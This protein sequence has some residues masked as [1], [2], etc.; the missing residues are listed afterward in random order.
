MIAIDL[1][2]TD[3]AMNHIDVIISNQL[4]FG[5]SNLDCFVKPSLGRN[6]LTLRLKRTEPDQSSV[7]R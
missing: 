6:L 7:G 2:P 1:F 5:K 3:V 4:R